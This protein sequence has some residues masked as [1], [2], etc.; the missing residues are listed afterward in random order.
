MAVW[1]MRRLQSLPCQGFTP[2]RAATATSARSAR[3]PINDRRDN[4]LRTRK[5]VEL[6]RRDSL[7]SHLKP[8]LDR[9]Q[10]ITITNGGMNDDGNPT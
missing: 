1:I 5:R 6:W 7:K 9:P 3:T 2:A 4:V 10:G 8:A